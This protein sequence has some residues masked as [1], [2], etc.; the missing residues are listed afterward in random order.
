MPSF[1]VVN[2]VDLQEVSNAVNNAKKEILQ[3]YDFRGSNTEIEWD[4]KK[5]QIVIRT[6]DEMKMEAVR[7]MLINHV[8]RR[9]LDAGSMEFK[10]VEVA[11]GKTLRREV[12]IKEGIDQDIAKRIV[13]DVRDT[14]IKVQVSIQGDEL[15]VTGKKRDDLQ[16]VISLLKSGEYEIP[17]QFVNMRD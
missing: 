14:K 1:D 15:R 17:L 4:G 8:T 13:K 10:D 16:S 6:E 9:K 7:E 12:L 2:K 11:G 3:R 5:G